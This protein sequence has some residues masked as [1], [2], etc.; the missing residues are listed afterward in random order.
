MS[1]RVL[2]SCIIA[3]YTIALYGDLDVM[4]KSMTQDRWE[5]IRMTNEDTWEALVGFSD[6]RYEP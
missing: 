5:L 1:H 4:L 2:N 6:S 3:K